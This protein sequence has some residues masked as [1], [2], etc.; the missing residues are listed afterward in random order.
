MSKAEILERFNDINFAYNNCTMHDSLSYV[1]D[2]F[3]QEI[4]NKT[5]DEF[6][7]R[8]EKHQQ[9]NWVDNLEYGITWSDIEEI[10]KQMKEG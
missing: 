9:E 3:E 1:L 2:E 5:I 4:R 6:V 8:L 7:N 10:I